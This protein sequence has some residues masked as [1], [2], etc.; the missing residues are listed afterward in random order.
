MKL[1]RYGKRGE[2]SKINFAFFDEKYEIS[3]LQ[4]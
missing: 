1:Y 2:L 4:A 3:T